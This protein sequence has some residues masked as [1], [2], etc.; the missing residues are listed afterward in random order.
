MPFGV[1]SVS[2]LGE[3]LVTFS[4]AERCSRFI[5]K[6]SFILRR[7]RYLT[8]PAAGP[9]TFLTV[10]DA[11]YEMPDSAIEE[12]LKLYCTVFSRRMGRIQGF[13][14]VCNGLRH[15]HVQLRSSVPLSSLCQISTEVL[16]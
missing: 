15:Y 4:R 8:H 13:Q 10:Y 1:R 6:S 2:L 3:V 12:R 11:P 14:D 16:S 5:E 9:L 7:R